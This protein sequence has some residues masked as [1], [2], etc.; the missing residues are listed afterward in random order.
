VDAAEK[1]HSFL[2]RQEESPILYNG[3]HQYAIV[4]QN[5][6]DKLEIE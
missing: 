3:R 1:G 4:Q 2:I 5:V 6:A